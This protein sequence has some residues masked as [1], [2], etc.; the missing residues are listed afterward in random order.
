MEGRAARPDPPGAACPPPALGAL[1]PTSALH[2]RGS[3]TGDERFTTFLGGIAARARSGNCSSLR[4]ANAG[5]WQ[6]AEGAIRHHCERQASR[7]GLAAPLRATARLGTGRSTAGG[8]GMRCRAVYAVHWPLE[9]LQACMQG[10]GRPR[11]LHPFRLPGPPKPVALHSS[12]RIH[13]ASD[14]VDPWGHGITHRAMQRDAL[15]FCAPPPDGALSLLA[16]PD[17]TA[18]SCSSSHSLGN[19]SD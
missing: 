1:T 9:G 3:Q 18:Y 5:C 12:T 11:S 14:P 10:G 15:D 13:A 17:T 19:Q 6:T 8:Q 4:G 7:P 2:V 16:P